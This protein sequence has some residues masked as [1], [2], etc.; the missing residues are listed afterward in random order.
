LKRSLGGG[1]DDADDDEIAMVSSEITLSLVDPFSSQLYTIP[2][3]GNQCLHREVFD[4]ETFLLSRLLK[5][6]STPT[7]SLN[8]LPALDSSNGET[9]GK[10]T[11][12]TFVDVWRCPICNEDAR[13]QNL[14][15]DEFLVNVRRK[16][17]EMGIEKK[18]KAIL[19]NK[20][21][22]WKPRVEGEQG[23]GKGGGGGE[24]GEDSASGSDGEGMYK[25]ARRAR[26]RKS[27]DVGRS[28]GTGGRGAAAEREVI[29][30]SD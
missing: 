6:A 11:Q 25:E 2:V 15:V 13:P 24:G 27:C 10:I 5:P 16:L 22:L 12:P 17:E 21:G 1:L 26:K 28:N 3:R 29:D 14:I 9:K 30:L 18:A 20:E 7:S 23:D 4:L 8:I 19:V